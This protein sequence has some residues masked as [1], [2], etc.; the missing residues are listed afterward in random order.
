MRPPRLLLALILA[1]GMLGA[2]CE[3]PA[4]DVDVRPQWK[5]VDLPMPPGDPGRL[6]LRDVA[7]CDGTWYVVGAVAGPGG[8]TRPA[9][10]TSSDGT[11]WTALR[12]TPLPDRDPNSYYGKR[13]ILYA[14]GCYRG[15]VAAIGAKAGGAHG[16]PR[17]STWR[18]L[19]D[20]SLSQVP[21]D[22]ELYGGPRAVSVSRIAG[23]PGGWLMAGSR[24]SGAA[25]WR[26]P[27]AAGFEILE[28]VA[29]LANDQ[30][31]ATSAS[32]ALW[33]GSGWLVA[34]SGRRPGRVDRDPV[35]WASGDGRRWQRVVLPATSADEAVQRLVAMPDG[36]LALGVRGGGFAAWRGTDADRLPTA[37]GDWRA[38]GQFGATGSGAVAGIEAAAPAGTRVVATAVGAD[39]HHVWLADEVGKRW[40]TMVAPA[41]GP[42]GGDTAASVAAG[43]GRILLTIDDGARARAWIAHVPQATSGTG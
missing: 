29:P 31:M 12:M 35:V 24:E 2:G 23:G 9:V 42:A 27:D 39:G 26:S 33:A 7:A 43:G 8:A 16:N 28:G 13:A 30:A 19:A 20:G 18:Q 37:G 41:E 6:M 3:R 10:W 15:R 5:T 38:I 34:G 22:F 11:S 25:V 36:V 1:L 40:S 4:P 21:A 17:V 14:V 32:D